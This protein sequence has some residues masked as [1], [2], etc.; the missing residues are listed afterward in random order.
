LVDNVELVENKFKLFL[1]NAKIVDEE[2]KLLEECD[3]PF[4]LE[5]RYNKEFTDL[6]LFS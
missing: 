4:S 2:F 3:D 5:P 1:D 6:F